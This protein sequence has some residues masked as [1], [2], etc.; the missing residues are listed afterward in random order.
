M[1]GS[2]GAGTTPAVSIHLIKELRA[3]RRSVSS[4]ALPLAIDARPRGPQGPLA[5][6][7]LLGRPVLAHVLEQALLI[8]MPGEHIAIYAREEEHELLNNLVGER[9]SSRVLF[10]TGPP[11]AGAA[12][13]RTDRLYDPRRLRRAVR[14]GQD[15]ETAVIWRLDQG[16]SLAA[17]EEELKRRLTYQPL[18]R[19]WAFT[20]AE[21]LAA[22]FESSIVRPNA[23]TLTSLLLMLTAAGITAFAAKGYL[24]AL[25]CAAA[26]AAALV[27]D[28]ADG[29]LARLQ[30]TS[31]AFGRWL[32]HVCD[33]LADM[34]LHAASA[35]SAF[36]STGQTFW[37]ALG[38]LYASGKYVFVI[39]SV[40]G[41][42]LEEATSRQQ[43]MEGIGRSPSALRPDRDAR[44][45][46]ALMPLLTSA[47]RKTAEMI[48][49]ADV[50]W[51]LWIVLAA[52]GRL[53]LAL[54]V[55]AVYFPARAAAASLRKA[56]AYA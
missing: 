16:Q 53:E 1:P 5:Q 34:A 38:M 11:R 7:S 22:A 26:L 24:P 4:P 48:G 33:E 6:E 15:L 52:A 13:L 40:A 42:E 27:L 56:V 36:Q 19:Y 51:H 12:T 44:K 45:R 17:A 20:L 10:F 50:R 55:Y 14:T 29:R 28:T 21:R 9:Q 37:L 2:R 46:R 18:G 31:S 23:L 3:R 49:H 39:Q 25:A 54:L 30:G 47:L 35:W 43:P 32:D 41:D 8:G